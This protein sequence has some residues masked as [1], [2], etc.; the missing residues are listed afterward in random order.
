MSVVK[1]QNSSNASGVTRPSFFDQA[2]SNPSIEKPPQLRSLEE[3]LATV[4]DQYD[5][6]KKAHPAW[7]KTREVL[8]TKLG[9]LKKDSP[10]YQN[11]QGKLAEV[12]E[13]IKKFYRWQKSGVE[14]LIAQRTAEIEE[15]NAELELAEF[16]GGWFPNK[17]TQQTQHKIA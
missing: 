1:E 14:A 12:N 3:V 5:F 15:M 10:D 17:Q 6:M 4:K 7:V 9:K 11:T 2:S 8:E 13:K 16:S